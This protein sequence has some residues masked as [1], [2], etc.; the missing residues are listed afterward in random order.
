MKFT[1]AKISQYNF[2]PQESIVIH[3]SYK[4]IKTSHWKNHPGLSPTL[5]IIYTYC[6]P[7][8]S[9]HSI[10]SSCYGSQYFTS[11]LYCYHKRFSKWT[12]TR[13]A[14]FY[15]W[16]KRHKLLDTFI[17]FLSVHKTALILQDVLRTLKKFNNH[18]EPLPVKV[19]Y[20]FWSLKKV[21]D[22]HHLLVT[23]S[24]LWILLWRW[25]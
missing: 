20:G 9:E 13:T 22:Q 19:R 24:F 15:T 7:G 10:N 16:R 5:Y 8:Y 4:P 14:Q 23:G 6:N 3:N 21:K 2:C 12:V 25:H 17:F 11:Q 1:V 18:L